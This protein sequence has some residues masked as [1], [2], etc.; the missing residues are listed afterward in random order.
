MRIAVRFTGKVSC[1]H[2]GEEKLRLR[3][4]RIRR[5][6]HESRGA[7]PYSSWKRENGFAGPADAASDSVFTELGRSVLAPGS[8]LYE[9]M[10]AL[11]GI[12]PDGCQ[13]TSVQLGLSGCVFSAVGI[14]G[15]SETPPRTADVTAQSQR[16]VADM[17]RCAKYVAYRLWCLH[18]DVA[19]KITYQAERRGENEELCRIGNDLFRRG[20][21]L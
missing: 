9:N 8:K 16:R 17:Q 15:C 6:R 5:P 11:T 10:V 20:G 18:D 12:E 3:D 2:C 21:F 1:P 13:F 19:P 14:P 4:R 7:D